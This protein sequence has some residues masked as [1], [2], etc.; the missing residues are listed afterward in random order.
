MDRVG[1][2]FE[3]VVDVFFIVVEVAAEAYAVGP[4][5]GLDPGARQP[6]GRLASGVDRNDRRIARLEPEA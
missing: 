1:E 3:C 5:R 2:N 6:L 4:D